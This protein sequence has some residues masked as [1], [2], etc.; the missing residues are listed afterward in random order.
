MPNNQTAVGGW[1]RPSLYGALTLLIVISVARATRCLSTA[2]L[3]TETS[4]TIEK[5]ANKAPSGSRCIRSNGRTLIPKKTIN[6]HKYQ[7]LASKGLPEKMKGSI[8]IAG[9][10]YDLRKFV[11]EQFDVDYTTIGKW[12]RTGLLPAPLR[13]GN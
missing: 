11:Q 7:Q 2:A 3:E 13:L 5:G 1:Q 4:A 10:D 6:I 12:V 9:R 8:V